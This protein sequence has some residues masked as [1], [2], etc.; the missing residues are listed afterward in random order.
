MSGLGTFLASTISGYSEAPSDAMAVNDFILSRDALSHLQE[1]LDLRDYFSQPTID[2]IHRFAPFGFRDSF[3]DLYEY[4]LRRVQVTL[5][6][7]AT[8][9]TLTV[10]VFSPEMAQQINELLLQAAEQMV[11]QL[12][13]RA[14]A[15]LIRYAE[16]EVVSAEDRVREAA[17]AL[18]TFRD[19]MEVMD[20]E[21]HSMFHFEQISK[22]QGEL[23]SVRTQIAKFRELAPESPAPTALELRARTLQE[24]IDAEMAK[25]VGGERSL[26]KVAAKYEEFAIEREFAEQQLALSL[27][28]LQSA[29][30]EA[31]R[32]QIYLERI[33]SPNLPD[34]ALEPRRLKAILSVLGLGVIVWGVMAMLVV[35]VKEHR[36]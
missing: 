12:N 34:V 1:R 19:T 27:G 23:I 29:R 10:K 3:E 8:I 22:M 6:D 32:Q 35:G 28:A 15:D 16:L 13:D 30:N 11:N 17:L 2:L 9:S 25:V 21:R 36:S 26:A 4:Y 7:H 20:P 18:S 24:E 31:Q 5:N 14:R 33:S